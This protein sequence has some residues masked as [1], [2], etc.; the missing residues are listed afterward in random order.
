MNRLCRITITGF[1]V[2]YAVALALHLA[3]TLSLFGQQP[4]PLSA[5]FLIPLGLPWNLFVD[6]APE[7]FW[8]WLAGA[9]PLLNYVLL[10]LLCRL[11]QRGG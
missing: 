11:G 8:P 1:L 9:A 4:D 10:R 5:V 6:L 2:L 3:A 7:P